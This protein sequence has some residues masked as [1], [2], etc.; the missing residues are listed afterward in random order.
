MPPFID[1]AVFGTASTERL[2]FTSSP[3]RKPPVSSAAFHSNP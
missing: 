3:T 2:I 1:Y